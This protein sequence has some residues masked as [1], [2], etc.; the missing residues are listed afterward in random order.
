M[1]ETTSMSRCGTISLAALLLGVSA[2]ASAQQAQGPA[3]QA[4][5]AGSGASEM[6]VSEREALSKL[7]SAGY[8]EVRNVKAGKEGISA[9]A[10]KDGA[11][12]SVVIDSS[13]KIMKSQASQ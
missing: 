9:D 6:T 3:D 13:G 2:F 1:Q 7:E 5:I 8:K 11:K 12:V 10:T 4:R